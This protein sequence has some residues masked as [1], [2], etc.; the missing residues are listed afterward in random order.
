MC[1]HDHLWSGDD[2]VVCSAAGTDGSFALI[3]E[4]F[5]LGVGEKPVTVSAATR[6]IGSFRIAMHGN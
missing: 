6:G 5:D 3:P 4:I 1:V 2:D